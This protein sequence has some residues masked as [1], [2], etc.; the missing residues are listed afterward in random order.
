MKRRR[1][2][3]EEGRQQEHERHPAARSARQLSGAGTGR[4]E[5]SD[6]TTA[7]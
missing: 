1:K 3:I 4:G 5:R 2:K 7:V 6:A